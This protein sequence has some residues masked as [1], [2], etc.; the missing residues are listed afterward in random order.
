MT[1]SSQIKWL[2]S[3]HSAG[4]AEVHALAFPVEGAW[5]A[6]AFS[7]LLNQPAIYGLGAFVEG[8]LSSFALIQVV[9]DTAEI[10]TLATRPNVER[11][12]LASQLLSWFERHMPEKGAQTWLLDVAADNQKATSFYKKIGFEID[13]RRPGYYKR[14]EGKRIDAILMSKHVSRQVSM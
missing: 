11:S 6:A 1:L 13:G 2:S 3:A 5:G 4:L 7:D 14:L 12:G 9:T 10:L 8:E